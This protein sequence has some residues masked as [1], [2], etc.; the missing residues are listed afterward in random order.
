MGFKALRDRHCEREDV[1]K[2]AQ[3]LGR[4]FAIAGKYPCEKVG[5]VRGREIFRSA[6]QETCTISRIY[7]LSE[8]EII[9]HGFCPRQAEQTGGFSVCAFTN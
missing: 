5:Y 3:P 9:E 4:K 6:S 7:R 2:T 1:P 8:A